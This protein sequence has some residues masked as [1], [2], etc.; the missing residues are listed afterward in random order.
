MDLLAALALVLVL[1]GLT[2]AIFAGTV[3]EVLSELRRLGPAALRK[4]GIVAVAAGAGLYL[5][6]RGAGA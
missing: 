1:E 5:L 2:L 4:V 6:V 3:P